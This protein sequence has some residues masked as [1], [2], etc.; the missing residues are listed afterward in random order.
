MASRAQEEEEEEGL[1][2]ERKRRRRVEKDVYPQS[3]M[4]KETALIAGTLTA[5][6]PAPGCAQT[7]T[8]QKRPFHYAM[9]Y[10]YARA[11]GCLHLQCNGN[12]LLDRR[13]LEP[14][15]RTDTQGKGLQDTLGAE[16]YAAVKPPRWEHTRRYKALQTLAK[17]GGHAGGHYR[18]A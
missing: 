5:I 14:C 8:P 1:M 9:L 3:G 11:A 13:V 6:I 16:A 18:H 15:L 17:G 2:G 7:K 4:L 12:Q 10:P